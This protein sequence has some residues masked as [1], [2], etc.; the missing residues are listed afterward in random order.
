M[1]RGRVAVKLL[2]H[3]RSRRLA[4]W[5]LVG[6]TVYAWVSTLVPLESVDP[7]AVLRWDS[8][9]PVLAVVVQA[10]GLH[11]AFSSPVF[12]AAMALLT[13]STAACAWERTRD[14][15]RDWRARG[16]VS[17]AAVRRLRE[18]PTFSLPAPREGDGASALEAA[19]A[20]LRSLRMRVR[21]GRAVVEGSSGAVGLLGSPVFHW[22]LVGLFLAA[23][24][25]QLTR[26]EGFANV[27]EGESVADSPGSYAVALYR[28]PLGGGF[29]GLTLRVK[30]VATSHT[31][32]GIPRGITPLVELARGGTV[33][34][35]QWVYPNSPL[36]FG[37][38]VVHRAEAG[39]AFLGT[40]RSASASSTGTVVLYYGQGALVP[41]SF[42]VGDPAKGDTLTVQVVAVPGEKVAVSL[43]KESRF[44]TRT[45][46][47][48][49]TVELREGL[50]LR[51]D[52]LTSYAQLKVVNDSS[53][54][55]IYGM[56]AMGIIGVT[57]TVFLPP[58]TVRVMLVESA[59]R[60][61][62]D[63]R[64]GFEGPSLHVLV[65]HRRSDPAF[66]GRVERELR[67][68]LSAGPAGPPDQEDDA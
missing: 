5:Q 20:A 2:A 64:M 34:V 44:T 52:A 8:E 33:L 56:F 62:R 31:V 25:G 63:V 14:A 32:A 38:L 7:A 39:P 66:V 67:A 54:P 48:G 16:A 24:L 65:T 19:A 4:A 49:D 17:T 60:T 68:V 57:I 35:S 27:L 42:D 47:R 21:R 40:L 28:G 55:W 50:T 58:R 6:I 30:E 53:V 13:A 23:G 1:P 10:L 43:P 11:R 29:T 59:E 15:V 46:G 9:H 37:P 61:G 18:A 3:L 12:L 45:A 41:R 51:V 36:E 26:Y 22:A